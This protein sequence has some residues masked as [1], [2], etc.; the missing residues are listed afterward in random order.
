MALISAW[1]LIATFSQHLFP[2]WQLS[3]WI[4]HS[5]LLMSAITAVYYLIREYEQ[6][7]Q[8]S[9][10]RYYAMVSLVLMAALALLASFIFSWAVQTQREEMAQHQ[11]IE[12]EEELAEILLAGF[13]EG[14]DAANLT[15]L[16]WAPNESLQMVLQG[17]L[18]GMNGAGLILFDYE[19]VEIY[20]QLVAGMDD[21]IEMENGR[22]QQAL[23]GIPNTTLSNANRLTDEGIPLTQIQ[24]YVPIIASSG[25][26]L[27]VLLLVQELF[28][29]NG[30]E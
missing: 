7:R 22:L 28:G 26:Q 2:T 27:G 1:L 3:W 25:K 6:L 8:F 30:C 10:T 19:E 5:L 12:T 14:E 21:G 29:L 15:T 4:Y 23:N 20:S 9:L 16:L 17:G 18:I 13:T 24:T 11:A